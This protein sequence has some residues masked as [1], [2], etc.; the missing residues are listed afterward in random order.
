MQYYMMWK[1]SAAAKTDGHTSHYHPVLIEIKHVV[2]SPPPAWV[3]YNEDTDPDWWMKLLSHERG[4]LDQAI[5]S[6]DSAMM[7]MEMIHEA[8]AI[9]KILKHLYHEV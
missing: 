7:Q 4:A 5:A 9:V 3:D 2:E 1:K 8:A 6:G